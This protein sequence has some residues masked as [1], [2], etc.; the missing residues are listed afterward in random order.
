MATSAAASTVVSPALSYTGA[1]S[2]TSAPTTAKPSSPSKMVSSSRVVQPPG[3]AVP[4]A[5][6]FCQRGPHTEKK[7]K[8][9]EREQ[10]TRR[11]SRIKHIDIDAHV[12]EAIAHP[13]LDFGND[14]GGA[15]F[16]QVAGGDDFEAAAS[17][18][19]DVAFFADEGR[20]DARV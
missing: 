3:S 15:E 14:T 16:I 5:G 18:V 12:D 1:T 17:V 2:T 8:E 13:L 20:P 10:H 6:F 11:I 4:V 9:V 19:F 7:R